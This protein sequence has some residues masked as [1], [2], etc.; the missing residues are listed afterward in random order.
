MIIIYEAPCIYYII[1]FLFY[2]TC[3]I[4]KQKNKTATRFYIYYFYLIIILFNAYDQEQ[5]NCTDNSAF[6][7]VTMVMM[8]RM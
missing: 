4:N 3:Y 1:I 5:Q 2:D 7:D 6:G 8:N